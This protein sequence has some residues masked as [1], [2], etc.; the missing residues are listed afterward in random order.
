MQTKINSEI[1]NAMLAKDATKLGVLRMLK[2]T[3]TNLAIERKADL[4]DTDVITAIRKAIKTRQD[5]VEAFKTANRL[6]LANKE[7][8]EIEVLEAYLPTA[9]SEEELDKLIAQSLVESG[10]VTKKQMGAAMKLATEKAA[11][12]VDGKTLSTRIGQLLH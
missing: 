7:E 11:G 10:A 8:A 2:A 4:A 1:K 5:S 12:R 6:D 9:L 3:L